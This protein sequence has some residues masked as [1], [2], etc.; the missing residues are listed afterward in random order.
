MCEWKHKHQLQ[1][2]WN[3]LARG[4]AAHGSLGTFANARSTTSSF[5]RSNWFGTSAM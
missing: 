3:S 5:I 4:R 2:Y 1:L